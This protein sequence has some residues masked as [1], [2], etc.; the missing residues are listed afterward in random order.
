MI[1]SR[2]SLLAVVLGCASLACAVEFEVNVEA[3]D[4]ALR[5]APIRVPIDFGS[6]ASAVSL[7][8]DG[9]IGMGQIVPASLQSIFRVAQG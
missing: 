2:F 4:T 7:S 9:F 1:G 8:G 6:D 5:N 3:G